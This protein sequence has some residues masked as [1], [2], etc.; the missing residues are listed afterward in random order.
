MNAM[1]DNCFTKYDLATKIFEKQQDI[2]KIHLA[3]PN[4]RIENNIE[5]NGKP[6]YMIGKNEIFSKL[7]NKSN[8]ELQSILEQQ[9]LNENALAQH[10]VT[11]IEQNLLY[12]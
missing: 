10:I 4:L 5:V 12:I 11:N 7:L 1:L 6:L 3:N 9:N 2:A 8:Q